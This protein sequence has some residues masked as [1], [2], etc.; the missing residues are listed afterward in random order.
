MTMYELQSTLSNV[1]MVEICAFIFGIVFFLR[2]MARMKNIWLF[3]PHIVRGVLGLLICRKIPK[4]HE[5][6]KQLGIDQL[7]DT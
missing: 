4:S 1:S 3:A 5:I 6:V 7:T 2:L